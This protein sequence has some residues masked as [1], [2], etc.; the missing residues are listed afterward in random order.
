LFKDVKIKRLLLQQAKQIALTDNR[1][2]D[3]YADT[4]ALKILQ[5]KF[6]KS[7]HALSELLQVKLPD[8]YYSASN[9]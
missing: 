4:D 9:Y 8:S 6:S 3:W 5:E 1:Q 7:N 2:I